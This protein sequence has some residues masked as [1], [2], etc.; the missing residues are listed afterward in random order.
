MLD[1]KLYGICIAS[2]IFNIFDNA[3]LNVCV[4]LQASTSQQGA[5]ETMSKSTNQIVPTAYLPLHV[6][7]SQE[8]WEPGGC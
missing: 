8:Q 7:K 2:Q 4:Q 1:R 3:G 6:P 5:D